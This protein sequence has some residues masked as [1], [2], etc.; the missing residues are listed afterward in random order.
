MIDQVPVARDW[1]ELGHA[2]DD[3][4]DQGFKPFDHGSLIL[5]ES[6]EGP[7]GPRIQAVRLRLR[8]VA[9]RAG[10]PACE[11]WAWRRTR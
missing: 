1:Q 10:R 2:L 4:Q 5:E 3:A 9:F 6:D 11:G 8:V 7:G